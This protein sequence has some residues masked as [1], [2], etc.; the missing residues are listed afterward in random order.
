M[1]TKTNMS[2]IL[3]NIFNLCLRNYDLF[4]VAKYSYSSTREFQEQVETRSKI[5]TFLEYFEYISDFDCQFL[6]S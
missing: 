5:I 6:A 1:C 4:F 3:I 2:I